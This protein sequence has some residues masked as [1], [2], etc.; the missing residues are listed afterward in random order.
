MR[1][2]RPHESRRFSSRERVPPPIP[3]LMV[4]QIFA[5]KS[6]VLVLLEPVEAEAMA[7]SGGLP[8]R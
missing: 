1:R 7:N 8:G 5:A 2:R 4:R 6:R 3:V